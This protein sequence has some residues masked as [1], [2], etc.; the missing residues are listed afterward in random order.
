MF[1]EMLEQLLNYSY[2]EKRKF[3]IVAALGMTEIGD[4]AMLG[5]NVKSSQQLSQD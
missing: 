1:D 4:E 5:F 2:E 3:D